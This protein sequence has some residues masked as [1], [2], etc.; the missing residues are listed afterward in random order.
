MGSII[1]SAASA[2]L[3]SPP[4]YCAFWVVALGCF[5]VAFCTW[6]DQRG[7]RKS[8]E[9]RLARDLANL[10]SESEHNLSKAFDPVSDRYFG[11][12]PYMRPSADSWKDSVGGEADRG[13][14]K[15]AQRLRGTAKTNRTTT[16]KGASATWD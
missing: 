8:E 4:P 5:F 9:D 3:K 16:P 1:L 14:A 7:L 10:I 6:R 15:P 12:G 13:R 11:G 2:Y